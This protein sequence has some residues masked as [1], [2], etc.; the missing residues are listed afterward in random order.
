[1]DAISLLLEINVDGTKSRIDGSGRYGGEHAGDRADIDEG[2]LRVIDALPGHQRD[3]EL[4][5]LGAERS[6]ADG[7]PDEVPGLPNIGPLGKDRRLRAP[8]R[9]GDNL[10]LG[11][12]LDRREDAREAA[13]GAQIGTAADQRSDD[14]GAVR[15]VE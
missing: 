14:L 3:R 12:A 11:A 2:H 13:A 9:S 5:K 10:D 4:V 15:N 8:R 7:L 1:M 6:G